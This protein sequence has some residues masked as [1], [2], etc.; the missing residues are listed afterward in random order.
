[1]KVDKVKNLKYF[2]DLSFCVVAEPKELHVDYFIY[3][4]EGVESNGAVWFH[5]KGSTHCP[6][7]VETIDEA[8]VFAHGEVKWD[9]CSNWHFDEQDRCMLHG[10]SREYLPA[11][12]EVLARCW[13]WTAELCEKWMP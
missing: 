1:M 8:E 12:G 3:E 10:C 13:D 2:D 11:L 4:T 5:K 7:P 6:D 9:G